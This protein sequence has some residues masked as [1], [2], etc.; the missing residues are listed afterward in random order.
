MHRG[1][2]CNG[3]EKVELSVTVHGSEE[4]PWQREQGGVMV[5]LRRVPLRETNC[6]PK[7]V[8]SQGTLGLSEGGP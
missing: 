3:P 5:C 2:D 4:K 1:A 7:S 8:P 6:A